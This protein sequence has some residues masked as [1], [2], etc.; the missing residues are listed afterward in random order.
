MP[1]PDGYV[2]REGDVVNCTG[3]IMFSEAANA[4]VERV[5]VMIGENSARLARCDL[6]LMSRAWEVGD[7]AKVDNMREVSSAVTVGTIAAI[8]GEWCW[9][10]PQGGG[11]PATVMLQFL[12][13]VAPQAAPAASEGFLVD[14]GEPN[15]FSQTVAKQG[16]AT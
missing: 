15:S 9:F 12:E 8:I 3:K 16:I 2:A 1:L 4:D 11:P 14:G 10:V 7:V 5:F 6:E 13:Y